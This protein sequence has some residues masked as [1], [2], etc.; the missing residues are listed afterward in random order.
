MGDLVDLVDVIKMRKI[1]IKKKKDWKEKI[2]VYWVH[3][4]LIVK[5]MAVMKQNNVMDLLDIVGA[6]MNLVLKLKELVKD[7]VDL[8]DVIKMREI[9]IKKKKDWKE[10]IE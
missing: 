5:M 4:L 2:E 3:S 10:R 1:V 9:V 6:L 7:L 8:V